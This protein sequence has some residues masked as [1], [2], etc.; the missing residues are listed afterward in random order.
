[1]VTA[2]LGFTDSS[3]TW[4]AADRGRRC[5]SRP[6]ATTWS[7][8]SAAPA[9]TRTGPPE[10]TRLPDLARSSKIRRSTVDPTAGRQDPSGGHDIVPDSMALV[11]EAGVPT[12]GGRPGM[13]DNG[14]TDA[15]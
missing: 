15:C 5:R 2:A 11:Q 8:C 1:M 4:R 6:A 3:R 7:R 9:A 10:P 14:R 12:N 13:P